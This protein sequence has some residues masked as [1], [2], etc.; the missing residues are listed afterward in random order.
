MLPWAVSVKDDL[1]SSSQIPVLWYILASLEKETIHAVDGLTVKKKSL[2]SGNEHQE[3]Q[4]E[5][6][7]KVRPLGSRAGYAQRT[8]FLLLSW[9]SLAFP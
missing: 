2:K 9:E 8:Q 1:L 3:G 6:Q 5:Q 7:A 4:K